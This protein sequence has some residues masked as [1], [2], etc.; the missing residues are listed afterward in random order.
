MV[1]MIRLDAHPAAREGLSWCILLSGVL[2]GGL[3]LLH[4]YL[5][6]SRNVPYLNTS[7]IS[8]FT[9]VFSAASMIWRSFASSKRLPAK[10]SPKGRPESYFPTGMTPKGLPVYA[11]QGFA[12]ITQCHNTDRPSHCIAPAM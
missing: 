4:Q 1:Y 5:I 7:G 6:F 3:T 10:P 2:V 12:K 8:R 11:N 9:D